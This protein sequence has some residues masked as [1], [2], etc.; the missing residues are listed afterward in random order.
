MVRWCSNGGS[1][2]SD[3]V[4]HC[5]PPLTDVREQLEAGLGSWLGIGSEEARWLAR[6]ATEVV[7]SDEND[8]NHWR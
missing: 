6:L 3:T 5:W 7:G 8:A 2:W 4:D 1:R